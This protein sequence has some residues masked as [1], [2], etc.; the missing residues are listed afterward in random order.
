MIGTPHPALAAFACSISPFPITA[1]EK[2]RKSAKW[3]NILRG[4]EVRVGS[5]KGHT[6]FKSLGGWVGMNWY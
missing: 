6:G 1:E 4:L 3:N 5:E 2:R